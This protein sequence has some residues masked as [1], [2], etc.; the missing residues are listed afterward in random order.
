MNNTNYLFLNYR[1]TS[2]SRFVRHMH[3][4]FSS[5]YTHF[6]LFAHLQSIFY[7]HKFYII[8]TILHNFDNFPKEC[9]SF[10]KFKTWWLIAQG[11]EGSVQQDETVISL[12]LSGFIARGTG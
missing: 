12:L 1:K 6:Y 9:E 3:T 11:F 7:I 8:S 4:V 10:S 5:I 2:N